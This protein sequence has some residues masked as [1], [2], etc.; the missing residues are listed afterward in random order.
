MVPFKSLAAPSVAVVPTCPRPSTV[1]SAVNDHAHPD[2]Q[3]STVQKKLIIGGSQTGL[4]VAGLGVAL[5]D[6]VRG[7][8]ACERSAHLK[9]P[10]CVLVA[11]GV[12]RKVG[13]DYHGCWGRVDA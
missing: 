8:G 11:P 13:G 5:Q 1:L 9:D 3:Q 12:E 10:R 7:G 4:D 6:D 2:T